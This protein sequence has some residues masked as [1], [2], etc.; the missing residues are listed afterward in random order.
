[1]ANFH[2]PPTGYGPGSQPSDTEGELQYIA[3]PKDMRIYAPHI[4]EVEED[5]DLTPAL[6]MLR[7]I[8]AACATG[9][10][11]FFDLGALNTE[12][13]ALMIETMGQGE[14][15]I[16]IRGV[17]AIAI[18][19]SVFAGVWIVSG[20]NIDGVEVAP[21]PVAALERSFET[22]RVGKGLDTVQG[23]GLINAPSIL[24]ELLDRSKTLAADAPPHVINLSLLPHSEED[25]AWLDAALGDGAVSILSR[26]YGNC[27]V[28]AT[29]LDRVWRVQ[30]FNST[31]ILIL[32]TFEV[33]NMPEVVLAAPEDLT[34]SGK[35]ILRVL[36]AL[37]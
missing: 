20:Q 17:P 29:A 21:V 15:S 10:G 16:K 33:T 11:A 30:F 36:E 37:Q 1:M 9:A 24:V 12:N 22:I 32:D 13:R 7:Q 6:D 18:Q 28:S 34:D 3:M 14:V 26:G 5:V 27:R 35:R 25:L 19:E 8:A 4:P 2:L 31:D 23:P